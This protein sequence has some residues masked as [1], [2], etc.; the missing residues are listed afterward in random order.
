[1]NDDETT[2]H[3][4]ISDEGYPDYPLERLENGFVVPAVS[5]AEIQQ[6]HRRQVS[7]QLEI[8]VEGDRLGYDY[9]VHPEHHFSLLGPTSTNP[10]Q[11]QSAIAAR[12]SGIRLLQMA[13]ILPWHDPVRLA[14]Q[15]AMLDVLS[16]GRAEVGVGKGYGV[17]ETETFG[18]YWGGSTSDPDRHERTFEEKLEILEQCWTSELVSYDG[19]FHQIPPEETTWKDNQE[20]HY[21]ASE[22]SDR[23]PDEYL[24]VGD[25]EPEL[26]SV[27]VHPQPVSSPHPQLWKPGMSPSAHERAAERGFNGCCHCTDFSNV[28]ERIDAYHEAA[29]RAGWPDHRPEHDGEPLRRGWDARRRRGVAAI[30]IVFNTE[31]ADEKSYERWKRGTAFDLSDSDEPLPPDD[32]AI[33]MDVEATVADLDAPLVGDTE[34]IIDGIAEFRSVCGYDDFVLFLQFNIP[35]LTHEDHLEQLR[36]FADDIAPYFR[37]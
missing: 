10:V 29:E 23:R 15:T 17:V 16:D 22:A 1:M 31:V 19:E 3:F 9:V 35:G 11:I 36:A 28:K 4:G 2:V 34:E 7:N 12:T 20:Y 27:P 13:N 14:E 18:Q 37:E 6:N 30:L 26:K 8:A 32:D 24:A 25:A 33:D 5:E 21:L